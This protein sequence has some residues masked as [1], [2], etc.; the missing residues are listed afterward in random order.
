MFNTHGC[1]FSCKK[2]KRT[3][4]IKENEGHGRLD[5]K[6]MEEAIISILCR[7]NFPHNPIDETIFLLGIPKDL[8]EEELGK[9]KKDYRKIRKYLMRQTFS[10]DKESKARV[11][12]M[13]LSFKEFLF[14]VGMV[15]EDKCF[16]EC[17]EDDME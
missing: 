2:K 16:D 1:T 9:R 10:E 13:N 5:D 6:M 4:H 12:L 8:P 14:E 3:I 7:Y 17:S 15:N 11:K